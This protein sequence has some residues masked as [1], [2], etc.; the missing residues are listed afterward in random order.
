MLSRKRYWSLFAVSWCTGLGCAFLG[1]WLLSLLHLASR[2]QS[3]IE[4][5]VAATAVSFFAM[6]SYLDYRRAIGDPTVPPKLIRTRLRPVMRWLAVIVGTFSV[7]MCCFMIVI[8]ATLHDWSL[9]IP[10]VAASAF[11]MT[12]LYA[13][14]TGLDPA[15]RLNAHLYRDRGVA[16]VTP[17]SD[18]PSA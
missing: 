5:L 12:F 10:F 8:A 9:A 6:P 1:G 11:G 2:V 15:A 14:V 3:A 18:S 17:D 13:G 7:G 16:V 4:W